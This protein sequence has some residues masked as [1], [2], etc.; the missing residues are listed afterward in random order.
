[1]LDAEQSLTPRVDLVA[2]DGLFNGAVTLWTVDA[3]F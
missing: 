3:L 2:L 1:M